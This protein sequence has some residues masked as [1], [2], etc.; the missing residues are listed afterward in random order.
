MRVVYW[1]FYKIIFFTKCFISKILLIKHNA[2]Y[3]KQ[4]T[5]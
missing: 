5:I 3:N 2:D 4:K 1:F